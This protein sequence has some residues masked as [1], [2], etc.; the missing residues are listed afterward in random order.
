VRLSRAF[1]VYIDGWQTLNQPVEP[2]TLDL[3]A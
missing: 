3:A 1:A 2:M